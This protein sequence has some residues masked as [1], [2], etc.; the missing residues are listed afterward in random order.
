MNESVTIDGINGPIVVGL[1]RL[2]ERGA[3]IHGVNGSIELRLASGLDADLIAKGMN[4]N[5]K[6]DISDVTVQKENWS[7][8][9]ARI[10]KGG[11]EI[12]IKGINGN[13][14]L[15]RADRTSAAASETPKASSPVTAKMP[16]KVD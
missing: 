8:Y 9:S 11:P 13:V 1:N 14:R 6:S 5:V 12:S 3:E 4:G 7:N 16:S 10:G 15:T 2:G